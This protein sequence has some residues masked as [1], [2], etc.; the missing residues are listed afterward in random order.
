MPEVSITQLRSMVF[1]SL[2]AAL[3]AAGAYIQVPLG[4]VPIV[5]Q[6]LFVLLAGLLLGWRWGMA[7]MAV[8]LLVGVMG[9]PVF[10]GGKGG[11]AT[12]LGPT[13]GY[14]VGFIAAATLAG[15]ITGR[16]AG[17]LPWDIAAVVLG[18]L[19]IYALGVPWL[20]MVTAMPWDKAVWIGVA[21]FLAGDV[22]KA[23]AAVAL[24]RALRPVC[25]P[26]GGRASA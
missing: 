16:H 10:A 24:A 5:M 18:S 12:L 17:R 23:A 2:L 21:P 9:I 6:N 26:D 19:I 22:L 14:L 7:S 20:K 25:A 1:A 3:T 8:Y 13:G 4:P 15:W 11:I